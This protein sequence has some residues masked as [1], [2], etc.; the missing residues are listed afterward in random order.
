MWVRD[1]LKVQRVKR[2]VDQAGV[3][4]SVGEAITEECCLPHSSE[5][6]LGSSLFIL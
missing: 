5:E 3:E 6:D 4:A 1:R 2:S